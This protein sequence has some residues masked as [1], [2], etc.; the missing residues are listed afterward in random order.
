ME[1][2]KTNNNGG[3]VI[4][5][6][7]ELFDVALCMPSTERSDSFMPKIND[8]NNSFESGSMSKREAGYS[9][10]FLLSTSEGNRHDKLTSAYYYFRDLGLDPVQK[11]SGLNS[12]LL[13]PMT[14]PEMKYIYSIG[15]KN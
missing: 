8:I 14:E 13:N 11:V 2:K 3:I 7:G 15:R 1:I 9:K 5:N 12:M 4:V 10:W 6:N